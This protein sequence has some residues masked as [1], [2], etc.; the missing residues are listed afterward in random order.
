MGT[1]IVFNESCIRPVSFLTSCH[2]SNT[3][4]DS[5]PA[6]YILYYNWAE[7]LHIY[8]SDK[9]CPCTLLNALSLLFLSQE[10]EILTDIHMK[11]SLKYNLMKF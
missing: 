8:W 3:H 2:S 4:V 1:L 9:V 5:C 10:K 7:K 6:G 11:F